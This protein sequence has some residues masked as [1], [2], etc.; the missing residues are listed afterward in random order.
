MYQG[1]LR[2]EWKEHIPLIVP[3]LEDL[4]L[5]TSTLEASVAQSVEKLQN[6]SAPP[7]KPDTKMQEIADMI[8]KLVAMQSETPS[9][10]DTRLAS[11]VASSPP[12]VDGLKD[13]VEID[14]L[15]SP[16]RPPV[17]TPQGAAL[18][19]PSC[20]ECFLERL[21][22]HTKSHLGGFIPSLLPADI[23]AIMQGYSTY[24]GRLGVVL[25]SVVSTLFVALL[26]YSHGTPVDET[27]PLWEALK[28]ST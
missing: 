23:G 24:L 5:R 12:L 28:H 18:V 10:I 2:S 9:T 26:W 20:Q 3:I 19:T 25:A 16:P 8:S 17:V 27:R 22:A 13:D 11:V 1:I 14:S 4:S 6:L 15:S 7:A 21:V